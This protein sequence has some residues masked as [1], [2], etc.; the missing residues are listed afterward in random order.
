MGPRC[1]GLLAAAYIV[2]ICHIDEQPSTV[3]E[4]EVQ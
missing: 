4:F 3:R 1:F 2:I